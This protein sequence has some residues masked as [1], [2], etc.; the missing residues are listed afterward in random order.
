MPPADESLDELYRAHPAGFVAGRNRLAKVLRSA[1]E[2]E[3]A[4]RVKRL[5]RPSVAAW[6][7]NLA[8]LSA[9]AALKE[10]AAASEA[11]E[12]AQRRALE[13]ED[14]GAKEWRAAA[15]RERDG[16]QAVI[17]AAEREAR[18]AGQLASKQALDLADETLRA[19][20]ADAELRKRVV[21][22]RLEREQSAATLGTLGISAS[23]ARRDSGSAKR[24][25]SAQARRELK[26]LEGE[27]DNA[28]ARE[29][30]QRGCV[31]AAA[32]AL[33]Q[34]KAA[35]AVNKQQAADL[36]RRVKAAGRRASE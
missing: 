8:A 3:E 7:I 4:E 5:R 12:L 30:R 26:R 13:G 2:R 35:L 16:A 9:P 27:L 21:A 25:D 20:A 1:G 34:E 32:E 24:R 14:E 23:P 15:A 19:A 22:G 36:R 18:N 17:A 6:L 29:E 10:F 31:D 33:R 28:T 11:L